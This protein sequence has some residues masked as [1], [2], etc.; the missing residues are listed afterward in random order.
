MNNLGNFVCIL[1]LIFSVNSM[2]HGDDVLERIKAVEE[3][4]FTLEDENLKKDK[5]IVTL[6]S[7]NTELSTHLQ[8]LSQEL[9]SISNKLLQLEN[10]INSTNED[11]VNQEEELQSVKLNLQSQINSKGS[12][13]DL[14][15]LKVKS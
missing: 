14:N 7:Q 12:E 9:H 1:F 3:R 4:V 5:I 11:L 15:T 13:M 6:V 10:G 2:C 8:S